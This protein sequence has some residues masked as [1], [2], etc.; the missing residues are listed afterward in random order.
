TLPLRQAICAHSA[1]IRPGTDYRPENVVVSVGAKHT[2]Y[3]L[4]MALFQDGDE[5]IIP[6]PYWVS[7]PAQVR[8]AGATPV[9]VNSSAKDGFRMTAAALAAALTPRTKAVVLCT[10]SNPTGAA[11]TADELEAL[12]NVLRSHTCWIIV[13]EIYAQLVY[14]DFDQRSLATVAPDLQPRLAVVDGVSKSYAMTGWRIGWLLAPTALAATC[15]KLQG[16]STTNAAA[17]AQAAAIAALE[18][19]QE[20]VQQM[21]AAFVRRRN[22]AHAA[23]SAIDGIEVPKPEGAFYLFCN[24][25]AFLGRRTPAGQ[26]LT[27]DVALA[28]YLLDEARCAL[29]PG[30]AFG[31]P[32]HV[33][34]SYATADEVIKE[35]IQRIAAALHKLHT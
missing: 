19:P 28:S 34:F 16:Q 26:T 29:V 15:D 8:L 2:L 5:V 31:A 9:I 21:R 35:G 1:T 32:G 10:P 17:V 33:R 12:A 27:D 13:D 6:A 7:Y 11:Y 24:M 25:D 22:L 20:A 4:A 14:D 18:G 3:N 30:S 23:L